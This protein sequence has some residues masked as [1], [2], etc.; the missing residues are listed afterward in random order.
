MNWPHDKHHG[1]HSNR[2]P[3]SWEWPGG[4]AGGEGRRGGVDDARR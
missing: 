4:H 3:S 2:H 1:H